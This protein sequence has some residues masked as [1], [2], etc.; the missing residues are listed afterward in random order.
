MH[1]LCSLVAVLLLSALGYLGGSSAGLR[2]LFG[3]I[4]PYAAILIFLCGVSY[5][6]IRWARTP[7][8]F[9]IP[10]TCGQQKSL[11]WIETAWIESPSTTLGAVARMALEILCF[12]SLFRNTKVELRQD[13]KLIYGGDRLLGIG[14]LVFHWA[15]LVIL[16]RHL[17]FFVDPVP[18]FVLAI[19][20]LDG[21]FQV[22]VPAA[23]ATDLIILAGLAYLLFRRLQ[24]GRLRYISLFTDYF[25]LF[26]LLGLALSG[27]YLRYFGRID[28]V[29]V[30][31]LAMGLATLSPAVP[32]G[33]KAPF[34][35]HL[36]LLSVLI[37]Y[38][39]FSKL[40]HMGGVFLSPT[41]N[42]A[43]NSRMKRHINP[44]HR[45]VKVHTYAEWENEF[46]DKIKA[47]G[48][49]LEKE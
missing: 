34:L 31:Q 7:V 28:L 13:P 22:A 16:L 4:I 35:M 39:P 5:R 47:C 24:D 49:P 17:R 12:R 20:N 46:R 36:F 9:R 26:L 27:V 45:P 15:F 3:I 33:V 8:P 10:T 25:A 21:F 30:K 48:L 29:E 43:N 23:Y 40:M 38:F 37:S 2:T 1:I 41:R 19:Q 18:G 14:A 11:P 42:L 32:P 44:W 6:V